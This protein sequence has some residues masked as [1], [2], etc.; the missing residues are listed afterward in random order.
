MKI[1]PSNPASALVG[2]PQL[3][4]PPMPP[5]RKFGAPAGPGCGSGF[6]LP[7]PG[8]CLLVHR[9]L[10]HDAVWQD[11]GI[12]ASA[13][14][15]HARRRCRGRP[16]TGRD[17]CGPA[18][19]T[20]RL[21]RGHCSP[22]AKRSARLR[23]R[24]GGG[25][26]GGRRRKIRR[27]R[28]RGGEAEVSAHRRDSAASGC[29]AS[30]APDIGDR[31]SG[32]IRD[33]AR[34][35]HRPAPRSPPA[36]ASRWRRPAGRRASPAAP[37]CRGCG[38]GAAPVRSRSSGVSRHLASGLRRQVPMPVQGASTSTRSIAPLVPLHPGIALAR[39]RAGARHCG[40]RRAAAAWP[41][42]LEPAGQHVAG[43]DVALVLH[44]GGSA[45]VLPPAPAQKSQTR[46]PGPRVGEQRNELR[47][48]VLHLDQARPE[49]G[50]AP[51]APAGR[52]RAVPRATTASPRPR[53]RFAASAALASS[54]VA[55]RLLARRSSGASPSSADISGQRGAESAAAA[56]GRAIRDIRSAPSPAARR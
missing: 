8:C 29:C 22:P 13:S 9:H 45:R 52:R 5:S 36:A 11:A 56:A 53:C 16:R 31:Q 24:L 42:R 54:R 15:P 43:D 25:A 14:S 41:T 17:G 38:A 23:R 50:R 48:L 39:Q 35:R 12:G 34:G 28:G 40:R 30:L 44:G 46:M 27:C 51:P 10:H 32:K 49:D 2:R 20:D 55:F 47:A 26:A 37:R 1:S 4:K 6:D 3:A 7:A 18:S 33:A 21:R 19:I